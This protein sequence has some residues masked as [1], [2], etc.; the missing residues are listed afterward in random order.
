MVIK[1]SPTA[2]PWDLNSD[3]SLHG[4]I[5][6]QKNLIFPLL[7]FFKILKLLKLTFLQKLRK[8]PF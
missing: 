4:Y 5:F 2:R 3:C 6:F 8:F 7:G 1:T